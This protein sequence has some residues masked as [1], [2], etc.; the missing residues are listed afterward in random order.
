M[1]TNGAKLAWLFAFALAAA[2]PDH[3]MAEEAAAPMVKIKAG[4]PGD[5]FGFAGWFIA[6]KADFFK[7]NGIEVEFGIVSTDI[8]PSALVTGGMQ[9]SPAIVSIMQAQFAGFEV[10]NVAL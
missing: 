1:I 4:I 3:A 7:R 2:L 6:R 10:R 9:A 5:N 8:V